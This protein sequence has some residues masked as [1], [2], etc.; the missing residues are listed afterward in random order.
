MTTLD[1]SI[2]K[3]AE[4]VAREGG[5][6]DV[7]YSTADTRAS[8][9]EIPDDIEDGSGWCFDVPSPLGPMSPPWRELPAVFRA[10]GGAG[11]CWHIVADDKNTRRSAVEFCSA[12][13]KKSGHPKCLRAAEM[14][15]TMRLT[16]IGKA[17]KNWR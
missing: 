6:P 16:A 5:Q 11:C 17:A 4:F 12:E 13:A 1:D 10:I 15:A 8:G 7:V 9:A 3:A 14:V 2:V